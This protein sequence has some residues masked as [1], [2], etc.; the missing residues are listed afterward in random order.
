MKTIDAEDAWLHEVATSIK[1]TRQLKERLKLK[2][3]EKLTN[4]KNLPLRITNY[5]LNVIKDNDILR[6]TVVPTVDELIVSEDERDDPLAEDQY[7]KTNCLIHKYPNRCLFLTTTQCF[8][9]CRYCTRSRIVGKN[10]NYTK[11]DWDEAIA[12]I[13]DHNEIID[14]LLS[15]GDVLMLSNSN[16]EYLL[17]KL[18]NISH[19]KILRIGT[20]MPV[21]LPQRVDDELIR[22]LK[23]YKPYINIHLTHPTEIT[24]EFVDCCNKLSIESNCILGSQTVL[25]KGINDDA[26]IL[27]ELFNKLLANR[28]VPYYLY[29]MDRIKGGSHFRCDLD[30]MIDIMHKLISWN[31]GR[32]IPD[33]II[34]CEIGKISLRYGYVEKMNNGK[35]KLNSFEKNKSIEY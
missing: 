12:Y 13:S 24:K 9:Y 1:N 15:G 27:Q 2:K 23:K 30:K 18:S 17:D 4:V 11:K 7:K 14:V 16:I 5:F 26:N 3:E 6:R 19:V 35:Y 10:K 31:S 20:K 22:I 29:Q 32:S 33:F 34:D 21:F 28:I 25:L 8:G